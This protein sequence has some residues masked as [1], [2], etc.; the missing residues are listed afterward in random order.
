MTERHSKTKTSFYRRLYVTYLI[1][2][3]INTVPT[4]TAATGMPRRTVQDTILALKELGI[5]C[6]S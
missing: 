6:A 5:Q 2:S 4:I 1:D 3:G